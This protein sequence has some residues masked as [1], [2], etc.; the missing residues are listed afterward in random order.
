M[1]RRRL[2]VYGVLGESRSLYRPRH[3]APTLLIRLIRRVGLA[4]AHANYWY[5]LSAPQTRSRGAL[6][7]PQWPRVGVISREACLWSVGMTSSSA[8]FG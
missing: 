5:G 8:R 3:A 1:A 2:L 6:V 7:Q 4:L